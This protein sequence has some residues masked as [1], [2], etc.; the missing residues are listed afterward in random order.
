MHN[1]SRRDLNTLRR[2][3]NT[4]ISAVV[5]LVSILDLRSCLT[6]GCGSFCCYNTTTP[7][8]SETDSDHF[9]RSRDSVTI[10]SNLSPKSTSTI[11]FFP[12]WFI[13]VQ[14]CCTLWPTNF[15]LLISH[16]QFALDVNRWREPRL[17]IAV[18]LQ[19]Q[20]FSAAGPRPGTGP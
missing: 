16:T 11:S 8:S 17:V 20:C 14:F 13:F 3:V 18:T 7:G 15:L 9:V 5:G 19:R 10:N 12:C 2:T 4:V 6:A 1:A